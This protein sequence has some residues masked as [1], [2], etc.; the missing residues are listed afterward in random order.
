MK[1][2]ILVMLLAAMFAPATVFCQEPEQKDDPMFQM[3]MHERGL[4]LEQ[5]EA[6]MDM[7]RSI[8]ELELEKRKIELERLRR[9]H[10]HGPHPLLFLVVVVHILLAVWV[11][12]DIRQRNAGSGIWIVI[13]LLAGLL[14]VLV[15]A[16][17]RLG[18]SDKKKA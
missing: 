11:Y 13:T 12:K 3:E 7:Q 9:A 6:Q 16:V 18:D 17:V 14:G 15:Y 2:C 5:R 1:R 8:H 10:K 4:E